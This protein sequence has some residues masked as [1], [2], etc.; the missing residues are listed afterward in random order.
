[1]LLPWDFEPTAIDGEVESFERWPYARVAEAVA[2]QRPE[3]YKPNCNL[4]VID[5][6]VRR[7]YVTPDAPGYLKLL[8]SLRTPECR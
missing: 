3:A 8:A 5:H 7:G 6:L 4:V 2:Y 1:M